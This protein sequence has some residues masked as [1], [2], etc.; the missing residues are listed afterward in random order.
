MRVFA[1]KKIPTT[2]TTAITNNNNN[3]YNN[4]INYIIKYICMYVS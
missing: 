3:H 1:C 2:T 4:N